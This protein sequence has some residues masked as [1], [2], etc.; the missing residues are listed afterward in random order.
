MLNRSLSNSRHNIEE[1]P[2]KGRSKYNLIILE[3]M[4]ED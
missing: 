2:G 1:T 4:D 3:D